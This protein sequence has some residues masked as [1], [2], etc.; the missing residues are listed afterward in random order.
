MSRNYNRYMTDGTAALKR[1]FESEQ[2]RAFKVVCTRGAKGLAVDADDFVSSHT[3]TYRQYAIDSAN[4][5][6][7]AIEYGS[8]R[9]QA[10]AIFSRA[11]LAM[12]GFA[13]AMLSVMFIVL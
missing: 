7:D 11:Q 6:A 2:G 10:S 4:E 12:V 8:A 13:T 1:D 3:V 9:G 5:I